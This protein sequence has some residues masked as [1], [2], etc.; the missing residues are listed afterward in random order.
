MRFPFNIKKESFL[1]IKKHF[2]LLVSSIHWVWTRTNLAPSAPWQ[3]VLVFCA[4]YNKVPQTRW[5]K[6]IEMYCLTVLESRSPKSKCQQCRHLWGKALQQNLPHAFLLASDVTSNPWHPWACS[7]I[8]P[9]FTSIL[10]WHSVCV[11]VCT[12][13]SYKDTDHIGL[14]PTL[15]HYD[16]ILTNYI[17]NTC[18]QERLHSEVMGIK[19]FNISFRETLIQPVTLSIE[20]KRKGIDMYWVSS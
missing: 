7:C 19:T 14:R 4:C 2:C 17:F 20:C 3:T 5:F 6:T 15:L 16:P 13:S 11:C 8:I 9:V 10:M 18:F 1:N 12:S